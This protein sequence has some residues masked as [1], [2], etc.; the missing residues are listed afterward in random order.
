M[1]LTNEEKAAA[2][3][4]SVP[5]K[6]AL[7]RIFEQYNLHAV[8]I[9]WITSQNEEHTM[10]IATQSVLSKGCRECTGK[11]LANMVINCNMEQRAAF[12]SELFSHFMGR[13]TE[14]VHIQPEPTIKQ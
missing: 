6:E 3:K 1:T 13:E 7:N 12:L 8:I 11:A 2:L 14:V 9:A 5:V 4:I 10:S